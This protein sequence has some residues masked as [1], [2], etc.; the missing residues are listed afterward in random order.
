[1]QEVGKDS[2]ELSNEDS[3][4]LNDTFAPDPDQVS[5]LSRRDM[6]YKKSGLQEVQAVM[7]KDFLN[8]DTMAIEGFEERLA[9]AQDD[10][11]FDNSAVMSDKHRIV[12][13]P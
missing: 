2:K 3:L 8:E 5:Q 11:S 9:L 6:D 10:M 13:T 7:S 4:Q 12:G 1:M